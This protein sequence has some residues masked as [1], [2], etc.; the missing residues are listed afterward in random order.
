M[1]I[2]GVM[3]TDPT[4]KTFR[5]DDPTPNPA[6]AQK[7]AKTSVDKARRDRYLDGP[8]EKLAEGLRDYD[9]NALDLKFRG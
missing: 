5:E 9:P 2:T 3:D 6:E 4:D 7:P 8:D 1:L